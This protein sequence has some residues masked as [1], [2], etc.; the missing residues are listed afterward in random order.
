VEEKFGTTS[1]TQKKTFDSA[2]RETA[3]E[4]ISSNGKAVPKVT[5][6]YNTKTG[7]L[8]KQSTTT[9]G[10]TQ[11]LTSV[12]N[13]LGQLES[14]TDADG[15]VSKYTYDVDGRMKEAKFGLKETGGEEAKQSYVYS[16]TTGLLSEMKDS[17]AGAFTAS[18][19]AEGKIASVDY[20][21]A[22]EAKYTYNP[23]GEATDL[24]YK[25]TAHCKTSC[26]ETWFGDAIT[27]SIH[28][29]ALKQ[30]SS[31][32]TEEYT[33]DNAGRLLQAQETPTGKGCTTRVYTYDEEMNRTSLATREP[34][35][36]GK[37]GG[38]GWATEHGTVVPHS[39]DTAN[40]LT[41]AGVTYEAFGNV[42]KMPASDAG[43][44]ELTS[45]YYDDSQVAEQ[46]Q[47]GQTLKY[48]YDPEGRPRETVAGGN[49][50]ISHYTGAGE[51][52]MWVSE[53][54]GASWTRNIPGIEG[55]L[56]A[57]EKDGQA[58]VLQ[59]HD[60]QGNVV[61]TAALSET[62]TKLLTTY[63]STEFGVPNSEGPPPTKYSWLGAGGMASEL[64]STGTVDNG[65]SSYVPQ[66]ARSLQTTGI[67]PPGAHPEGTFTGA[68]YV[69]QMPTGLVEGGEATAA[70]AVAEAAAERQ[71]AEEE[72]M[73][74]ALEQAGEDPTVRIYA[75]K[76]EEVAK[77]L[78]E[79]STF[80]QW[81]DKL[82]EDFD[83]A[84]GELTEIAED[85]LTGYF[86]GWDQIEKWDDNTARLLDECAEWIGAGDV[87]HD[88]YDS[89]HMV[90]RLKTTD[91][92]NIPI[93][94]THSHISMV[95][96]W[97]PAE[98]S[99]CTEMYSDLCGKLR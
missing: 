16:T 64:P 71:K 35:G 38:E 29:E 63:N 3:S 26:P 59:L 72:E 30:V 28:G 67:V 21:N 98:V 14:Y 41:D 6:E 56:T 1:R 94:F 80:Q 42:T 32:A 9:E 77:S 23:T 88:H 43:E 75:W 13:T 5:F 25:K 46:T 49:T 4:V 96:F 31:L 73:L 8:E 83:L 89:E 24:E 52:I 66:V 99:V 85:I 54:A 92:F 58:P 86:D 57:T 19:D 68:P 39:Y 65:G 74:R 12:R 15:N 95:N 91:L 78:E 79:V 37:C 22:I 7:T 61:G 40:R 87:G 47:D 45:S 27:P 62:E 51:A 76:A 70:K 84:K 44:H 17:A 20:P 11:T 2:G 90:C 82:G 33:Y 48:F 18:Y 50:S 53:E 60:L 97:D 69:T 55:M 34:A 93:P 10:K 81:Y 36:E